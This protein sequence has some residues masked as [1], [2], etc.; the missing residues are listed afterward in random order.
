[1]RLRSLR[2]PARSARTPLPVR[3]TVAALLL[4]GPGWWLADRHDRIVNQDRLTAIASEIAGRPVTVRCPGPI[5]RNLSYETVD[6]SVRFD[7]DGRPADETRLRKAPCAELDALA[8]GRRT[9]ELACAERST[10][11][12]DEAQALAGAVD[13]ITHEAWH[14]HGIAD[15][16]VTECRSLQT[17]AWSA[18]RL[19]ATEAQ[20]RGLAQ[21]QLATGYPLMPARYRSGECREGGALDLRPSD[22]AWP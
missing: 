11:C 17:M 5:G 15:E 4:G 1:M 7:A 2:T 16:A 20:A 6:G 10:A 22:P 3:A 19:G 13:V 9:T 14:L 18:Q 8:E 12:G 21:L